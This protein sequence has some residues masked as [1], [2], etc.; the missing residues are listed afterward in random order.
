MPISVP[1]GK[2][3]VIGGLLS[4][5]NHPISKHGILLIQSG[6]LMSGALGIL[7]VGITVLTVMT[8]KHGKPM[9]VITYISSQEIMTGGENGSTQVLLLL[10][11]HVKEWLLSHLCL[12]LL[13]LQLLLNHLG[14]LRLV[15]L[16]LLMTQYLNDLSELLL[17]LLSVHMLLVVGLVHQMCRLRHLG[18]IHLFML[19]MLLVFLNIRYQH[20]YLVHH[21]LR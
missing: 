4:T 5:I 15:V 14:L 3:V 1:G 2:V 20:Q 12:W 10:S 19:L 13:C 16:H 11:H 6:L 7:N 17:L 21:H 18:L 9:Y 8:N